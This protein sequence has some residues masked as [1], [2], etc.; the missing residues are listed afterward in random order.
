MDK[1]EADELRR[2][3]EWRR[4]GGQKPHITRREPSDP[5]PRSVTNRMQ[6]YFA[7]KP[8]QEPEHEPFEDDLPWEEGKPFRRWRVRFDLTRRRGASLEPD[9][10]FADK[11]QSSDTGWQPEMEDSPMYKRCPTHPMFAGSRMPTPSGPYIM[12]RLK[13]ISHIAVY[14][15]QLA[16]TAGFVYLF[17]AMFRG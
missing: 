9:D 1:R 3:L 11:P 16:A 12:A 17:I 2:Y 14:L 15:C 10:P 5:E 8:P 7:A 4:T 6:A 13:S